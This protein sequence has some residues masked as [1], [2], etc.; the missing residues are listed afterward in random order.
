MVS[1]EGFTQTGKASWYGKKFH[2]RK[3]ANGETYN[4]YA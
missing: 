1:S 3:T 2:G 4:M